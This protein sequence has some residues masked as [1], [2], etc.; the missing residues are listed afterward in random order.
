MNDKA[1]KYFFEI[2]NNINRKAVSYI[3]VHKE[4]DATGFYST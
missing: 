4:L 2:I 1:Q 3:A